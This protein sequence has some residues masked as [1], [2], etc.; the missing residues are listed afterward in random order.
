MVRRELALLDMF[1]LA[2]TLQE[3]QMTQSLDHY[4]CFQDWILLLFS[5]EQCLTGLGGIVSTDITL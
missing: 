3:S 4:Q 1:Q 5:K 2:S